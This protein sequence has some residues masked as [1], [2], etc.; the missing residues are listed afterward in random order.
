M[1]LRIKRAIWVFYI[2]LSD[3]CVN[4][5]HFSKTRYVL[6]NSEWLIFMSFVRWR[7]IIWRHSCSAPQINVSFVSAAH[8][9]SWKISPT[10]GKRAMLGD[11]VRGHVSCLYPSRAD[12]QPWWKLAHSVITN[13]YT[14]WICQRTGSLHG[15]LRE[16]PVMYSNGMPVLNIKQLIKMVWFLI[17]LISW[18]SC[19]KKIL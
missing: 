7:L 11:C 6:L 3:L 5:I 13:P 12:G 16:S 4:Q 8:W 2:I 10:G 1:S 17:L 9:C 15:M 19:L 14:R 18:N